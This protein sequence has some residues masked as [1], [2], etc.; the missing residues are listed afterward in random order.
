MFPNPFPGQRPGS[1][2]PAPPLMPPSPPHTP[3][4]PPHH[5]P[6]GPGRHSAPQSP[7]PNFV[8]PQPRQTRAVDAGAIRG[9]LNS[10]MYVWLRNGQSFWMFP[11][12]VGRQSISGY[13]WTRFGWAFTGF[14]LQ[15]VESFFCMR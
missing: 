8:P 15:V 5:Q 2:P 9:C 3:H 1:R 14:S 4:N 6:H 7:P 12:F 11:T 13:R 10:F